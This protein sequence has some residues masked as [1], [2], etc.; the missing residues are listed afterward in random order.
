[1]RCDDT[2]SACRGWFTRRV[3]QV[4][5]VSDL[6]MGYVYLLRNL[7]NGKGY[8]GIAL[9]YET[10]WQEHISA[11]INNRS[12]Y[13]LHRAIRKYGVKNFSAEVVYRCTEALLPAVERCFIGKLNTYI[14]GGAGYNQTLGGDGAFGLKFSVASKRQ[15]STSLKRYFAAPDSRAQVSARAKAMWR[16]PVIREK[17][18]AMLR[19]DKSD[20]N[21]KPLTDAQHKA[22]SKAARAR[23]R[24]PE[25][26]AHQKAATAALWG[27][28]SGVE[29]RRKVSLGAK[30]RYARPEERQR[31][32]EIAKRHW[33][34]PGVKKR[35]GRLISLGM[36]DIVKTPEYRAKMSEIARNRVAAHHTRRFANAS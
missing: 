16:N 13:P 12:Q 7:V 1:M 8:V 36:Q 25:Y 15:L 30:K 32:A 3:D 35:M 4:S 33:C 5:S 17:L 14:R 23:W 2:E 29:Q 26:R 6:R 18:V 22:R 27:G 10:R 11:A 24:R 34:K 21:I 20:W 31:T 28:I 9:N 19:G